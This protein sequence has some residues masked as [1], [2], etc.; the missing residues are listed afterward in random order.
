MTSRFCQGIVDSTGECVI[1]LQVTGRGGAD[2]RPVFILLD[3][4]EAEYD[5]NGDDPLKSK[6]TIRDHDGT[7]KALTLSPHTNSDLNRTANVR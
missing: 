5:G 7:W 1:V 4:R 3:G 2:D 6:W